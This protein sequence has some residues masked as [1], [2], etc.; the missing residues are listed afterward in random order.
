MWPRKA[1]MT[2]GIASGFALAVR[3]YGLGDKPLWLDE[4]ITHG[5]ANRPMWDLIAN[6]LSNHHFPTYFVFVRAFNSPVIDEWWLR[7]PSAVLGAACVFLIAC[8][9]A[10]VQSARAGLVAGLLMA[11]SPFEVQF[12]QEARPNTLVAC[13]VL[14]ALWGLLRIVHEPA[15]PPYAS[16]R[17]R[18]RL[19]GWTAYTLGTIGALSVQ[20]VSIPWLLASNIAVAIAIRRSGPKQRQ[21]ISDWFITQGIILLIWVP[22]LVAIYLWGHADALRDFRWFPPATMQHIGSVL[23]AVYLFRISEITTFELLPTVVPGFG[24]VVVG[25]ALLGSW[26]LKR[27]KRSLT[28]IALALLSMPT[29]ILLIS[30]VH[31]ILVPRY[32][33]WSTGPLFVLAGIGTAALPHRLYPLTVAGLAL[34]GFANLAPYYGFETKPRWDLATAYLAGAVQPGDVVVTNGAMAH[35]ILTRYGERYHLDRNILKI[36][37]DVPDLA[38][39]IREQRIWV[40]YGRTGQGVSPTEQVYLQKWLALGAPVVKNRFGRHVS[41]LRFD[42]VRSRHQPDD[43]EGVSL[44]IPESFLLRTDE[45]IE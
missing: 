21:F 14:V 41:V 32:L 1:F 36:A 33:I 26:H 13:L 12:S 18:R 24:V 7:L 16:D 30:T 34:A 28:V 11:L 4:I 23:S 31:A 38:H 25:L 2:G 5:R 3:L 20:L 17:P 15:V 29:C 37:S 9:A 44:T 43:R 39:Y 35:Y 19:A 40:V 22:V 42:Q 45:V 27:D 8:I 6:S 10:Q